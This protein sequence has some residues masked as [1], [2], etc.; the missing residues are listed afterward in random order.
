MAYLESKTIVHRD[1][2]ARNIMV[3]DDG[4]AKVRIASVFIFVTLFVLYVVYM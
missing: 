1:L 3:N 2:A 4:R